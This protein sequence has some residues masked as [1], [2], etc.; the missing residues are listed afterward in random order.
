MQKG[1]YNRDYRLIEEFRADGRVH[2]DYEYIGDPWYFDLDE[3]NVE[4]GKRKA[5]CLVIL[6]AASFVAA[7]IPYSGMMHKLW[8]ALP[9]V[10]TIL[11]VFMTADLVLSMRKIKNPMEHRHADKLNN[12]FPARTFAMLCLSAVSLIAEIVYLFINGIQAAGDLVMILCTAMLLACGVLL[13]KM[14]KLFRTTVRF[15]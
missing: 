6:S 14:R 15:S 10:F 3:S 13:F 7:L 2:T 5:L 1:K 4:K 9:F 8:I 11:P 12:A